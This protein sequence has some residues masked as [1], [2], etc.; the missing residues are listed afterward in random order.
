MIQLTNG[1][2]HIP[3]VLEFQIILSVLIILQKKP[4]IS[5]RFLYII[6]CII[7]NMITYNLGKQWTTLCGLS[8]WGL[9][10]HRYC[11]ASY[12]YKIIFWLCYVSLILYRTVDYRI[13]LCVLSRFKKVWEPLVYMYSQG[14]RRQHG[15][16][17]R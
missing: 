4:Q 10:F 14:H 11:W 17:C 7:R 1:I 15:K 12:F 5:P 8:T 9:W 3:F 16:I 13:F 6:I 2:W